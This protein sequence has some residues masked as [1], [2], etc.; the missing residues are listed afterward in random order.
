MRI[1]ANTATVPGDRVFLITTDRTGKREK[2][3]MELDPETMEPLDEGLTYPRPSIRMEM[4]SGV[5]RS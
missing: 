3:R 2:D 4:K 5:H 1:R